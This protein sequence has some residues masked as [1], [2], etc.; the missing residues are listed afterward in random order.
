MLAFI[1][2]D[3]SS[4]AWGLKNV[5]DPRL[6]RGDIIIKVCRAA[7]CGTDIRSIRYGLSESQTI[8]GHEIGG[9]ISKV[10]TDVEG[11]QI[12][13]RVAVAPNYGC[14][15]CDECV[16][17]NTH[18]CDAYQAFGINLPGGFAEYIR[19]PEKAVRQGNV[20]K[21]SD[22]V[23]YEEAAVNEPFSCVYSGFEKCQIK[24]GDDVL[25]IGAG[26]IGLMHALL[27]EMA[28]AG[29]V[30]MN[31]LNVDRLKE[32]KLVL[33]GIDILDDDDLKKTIMK[34]TGGKGVNVCVTACPSPAAQTESL[35]LMAIGGRV[36]FFGGIPGKHQPVQLD[37]NLIHYRQL[38]ITGSTRS[39]LSQYRKTL[40]LIERGKI[41]LTKLITHRYPFTQISEALDSAGRGIGLKTVIVISE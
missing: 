1:I 37:T 20:V 27:A 11:Y 36:N 32:C 10:A 21:L 13:D 17:G 2:D 18:L 7:I 28:G 35:S 9:V 29:A 39:S 15:L 41:D 24:P 3:H 40:K 26:P 16:S 38:M 14:G 8:I 12:G 34:R 4:S 30:F 22:H 5:P 31:D 19:I 23:S 6:E 25:I 33:P